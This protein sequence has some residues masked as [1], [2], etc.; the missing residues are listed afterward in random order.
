METFPFQS[1][2]YGTFVVV[3]QSLCHVQLFVTPWTAAHQAS[4]S[5]TISR[6][7]SNACPLSW[8]CH[9]TI[10]SSV[11]LFSS[12]PQSFPA[13]GSF[14]MSW[15]FALG[16]QSIGASASA[17]VLMNIQ[18]WF[19]LELIDLLAVQGTVKNLLQQHHLKASVLWYSA[20]SMVQLSHLY[21][22]PGKT[23]ALTV[24]TFVGKEMSLFFNMLSRFVKVFLLR[25]K[26]LWISWLQSLSAVILELKKIK[27]V[28]A[29][30]FSLFVCHEVMGSDAMIFI[31]W[32]LSFKPTFSLP[33]SLSSRGTLVLLHFLP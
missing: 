7:C 21:M 2:F 13:S 17:S 10:S 32:M 1:G 23:V 4:L 25:S 24:W 33:F 8:W 9:P 31:F 3:L 5:F 16:S 19:P 22:T 27:S 6:I 14:P 28:T 18:G 30:T 29:T 15:L 20:F 11:T 12:C 26:L